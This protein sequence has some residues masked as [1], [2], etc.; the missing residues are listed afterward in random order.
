MEKELAELIQNVTPETRRELA[1][2]FKTYEVATLGDEMQNARIN[3]L[4]DETLFENDFRADSDAPRVGINKGDRIL[5]HKYDFLLS[6]ADFQRLL[7]LAGVK[8][9][10]AGICDKDGYYTT[11][12]TL[13]KIDARNYLI[14]F[15]ISVI[16]PES[17]R[18]LFRQNRFNYTKMQKLIEITKPLAA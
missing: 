17:F 12:W 6:D 7:T 8:L 16:V 3:D 4:Y 10:A 5:S 15:I 11:N 14:D 13:R 2:R 9:E 1:E 18:P